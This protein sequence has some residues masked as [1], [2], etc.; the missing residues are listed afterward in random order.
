MAVSGGVRVAGDER[1]P[2]DR[3]SVRT[4]SGLGRHLRGTSDPFGACS[5]RPPN[6]CASGSSFV[7]LSSLAAIALLLSGIASR[8]SS[9]TT[10]GPQR[11]TS[12]VRS[13]RACR[14]KWFLMSAVSSRSAGLARELPA[15]SASRPCLAPTSTPPPPRKPSIPLVCRPVG[16]PG[17][18]E[19][20]HRRRRHGR[21]RDPAP[22]FLAQALSRLYPDA[23]CRGLCLPTGVLRRA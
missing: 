17:T 23:A 18:R 6:D 9:V 11:G 2:G 7:V 16:R 22:A 15:A 12:S 21:C 10:A 19:E 5:S 13:G 8:T 4:Q 14:R 20:R 1:F 3:E